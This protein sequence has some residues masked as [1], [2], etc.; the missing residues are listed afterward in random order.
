MPDRD[1][2]RAAEALSVL[3]QLIGRMNT[4]GVDAEDAVERVTEVLRGTFPE[5]QNTDRH[6]LVAAIGDVIEIVTERTRLAHQA[7]RIISDLQRSEGERWARV[8]T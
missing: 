2:R 5:G 1:R 7:H 6:Q 4:L 3:E 8:E